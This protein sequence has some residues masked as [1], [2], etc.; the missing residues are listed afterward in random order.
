MKK[1]NLKMD[2]KLVYTVQ[3]IAKNK[4]SYRNFNSYAKAVNVALVEFIETNKKLL[5]KEVNNDE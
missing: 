4:F 2:E 3:K 1:I 5:E